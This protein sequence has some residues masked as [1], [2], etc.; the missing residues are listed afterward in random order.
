[1]AEGARLFQIGDVVVGVVI[2]PGEGA[3]PGCV[4]VFLKDGGDGG[5]GNEKSYHKKQP[6]ESVE[7]GH[8]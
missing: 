4:N 5:T 6:A 7:R 3:G 1:M 8:H 2:K